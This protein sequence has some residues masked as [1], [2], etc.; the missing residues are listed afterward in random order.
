MVHSAG[1]GLVGAV[2]WARGRDLWTW[3]GDQEAAPWYEWYEQGYAR[4]IARR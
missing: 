3:T 2:M 1:S 4:P